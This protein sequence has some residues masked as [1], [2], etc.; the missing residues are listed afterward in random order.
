MSIKI[1]QPALS[2]QVVDPGLGWPVLNVADFIQF[3]QLPDAVDAASMVE[4]LNLG[5]SD[6]LIWVAVRDLLVVPLSSAE[7]I[8]FKLSVHYQS[9]AHLMV[10]L[11]VSWQVK[12]SPQAIHDLSD[13]QEW[14]FEQAKSAVRRIG[15]AQTPGAAN[16]RLL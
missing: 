7:L 12:S 6:V 1:T 16:S 3:A 8:W 2:T 4:V 13:R 11:P 15:G 5:V 14:Y 10:R 9:L